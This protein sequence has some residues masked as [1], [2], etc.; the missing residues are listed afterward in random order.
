M[1][2]DSVEILSTYATEQFSGIFYS[3]IVYEFHA[4]V[5]L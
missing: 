2:E 5:K 1:R 4:K 3:F